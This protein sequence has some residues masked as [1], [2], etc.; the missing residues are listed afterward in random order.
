MWK[1]VK[2]TYEN[3]KTIFSLESASYT[4]F[5]LM[6]RE[7]SQDMVSMGRAHANFRE[8]RQAFWCRIQLSAYLLDQEFYMST[9]L[10]R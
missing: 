4:G 2:D 9:K 6:A 1:Y 5:A 8:S 7:L 3:I 10:I